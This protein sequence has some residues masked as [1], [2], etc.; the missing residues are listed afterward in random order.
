VRRAVLLTATIAALLAPSA[1]RA[2]DLTVYSSLPLDGPARVESE[3][4]VRGEQLALEQAGGRAGPH[5]IRPVSLNDATRASDGWSPEQVSANARRAAQDAAT[6]AYIGEFN[7][8]GSAISI[9][10]LNEAGILQVSPSNAYVGLTRRGG[11]PGEPEKYYPT[12]RRTFGR[13]APGDHVQA[14]SIAALVQARGARRLFL[15]DDRELYGS[16]LVAKVRARS[17][18]RGIRVVGHARLA[19]RA[20]NAA[21]IARR[22]SASRANAMVFAGSPE[23]GAARLWEAI[24]RR[25]PRLKLIGSD[26]LAVPEFARRLSRAAARRT[27]VMSPTLD[28]AEYGPV[29]GAF[30]D[31]FR[32]RFG[33]EPEPYAIFG[34]EA[35]S[36][37]LDSIRRATDGASRA[38]VVD[39]FFQTRLRDSVIGRYSVD[40]SGDTTRSTYGVLALRPGGRFVYD[41]TVESDPP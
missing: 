1:S 30:H 15:V 38:A 8:G 3:D 40:V 35:M 37:V 33:K 34:Y 29:A 26:A 12:G 36:V 13:L 5:A 19:R 23:N 18:I 27:H 7:S 28:P 17:P 22:V 11:E 16:L 6:I 39:A 20:R 4:I 32:R 2:A 14:A 10:I 31:A 21:A 9:P 24:N 25:N 41:R